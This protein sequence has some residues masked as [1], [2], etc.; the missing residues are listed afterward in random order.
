MVTNLKSE[1]VK[2]GNYLN[3]S[4]TTIY[5]SFNYL[6]DA[7]KQCLLCVCVCVCKGV[8]MSVCACVCVHVRTSVCFVFLIF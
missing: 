3:N 1:M 5:I 7:F 2:V 6:H 4:S 8:C